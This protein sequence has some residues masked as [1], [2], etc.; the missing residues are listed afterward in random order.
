MTVVVDSRMPLPDDAPLVVAASSPVTGAHDVPLDARIVVRF[1]DALRTD[2]VTTATI[3]LAGA[4]GDLRTNV[5]VAEHGRLVF[6]WPLDPLEEDETYVLTLDGAANDRGAPLVRATITF[7]TVTRTPTVDVLENEA[8]QR[9]SESGKNGWRSGRPPSPWETLPPLQAPPGVTA[10]SGRV[11]RLDGR[12][13]PDV[14]L[15]IEG[16][17]TRTD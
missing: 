7:T 13:L 1:S 17:E 11:L 4:R 8:W 2:T 9:T 14:T 6:V 12:P 10:V 15:E 5:V 3:R 16:H